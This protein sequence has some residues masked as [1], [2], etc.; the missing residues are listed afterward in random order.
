MHGR[1]GAQT[2]G[3]LGVGPLDSGLRCAAGWHV[4][5]LILLR[6]GVPLLLLLLL[7]MLLLLLHCACSR[8]EPF[9]LQLPKMHIHALTE[10]EKTLAEH[11]STQ[12]VLLLIELHVC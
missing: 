12:Y 7:R 9:S 11:I 6:L 10:D 1:R 8:Q 4:R 5:L 3:G 2:C